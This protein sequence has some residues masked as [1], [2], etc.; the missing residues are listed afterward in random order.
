MAKLEIELYMMFGLRICVRLRVAEVHHASE[1]RKETSSGIGRECGTD[2]L[3]L[4]FISAGTNLAQASIC[5]L[6]L[7]RFGGVR[8]SLKAYSWPVKFH[9]EAQAFDTAHTSPR[10]PVPLGVPV[11]NG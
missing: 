4:A 7:A 9:G 10:A 2:S 3:M 6:A 8:A 1:L 11:S 5:S